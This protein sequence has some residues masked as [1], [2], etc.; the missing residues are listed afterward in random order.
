MAGSA[1]VHND[2]SSLLWYE[3]P[4]RSCPAMQQC[5]QSRNSESETFPT[6]SVPDYSDSFDKMIDKFQ[7]DLKS[8]LEKSL[9]TNLKTTLEKELAKV[10]A[11]KP[12]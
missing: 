3:E 11:A 4:A 9:K 12:T 7:A 2:E 1:L 8:S 10:S 5:S 6:F